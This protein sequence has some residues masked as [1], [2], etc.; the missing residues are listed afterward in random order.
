MGQ[1]ALE[2]RARRKRSSTMSSWGVGGAQRLEAAGQHTA[3]GTS[4]QL[5]DEVKLESQHRNVGLRESDLI[6]CA[7]L[8]LDRSVFLPKYLI[9]CHTVLSQKRKLNKRLK[10]G[11]GLTF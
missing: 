10:K 5:Y 9:C 2:V 4:N 8:H 11:L 1:K 3:E 7:V 6:M